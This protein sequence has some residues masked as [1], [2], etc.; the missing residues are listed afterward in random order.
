MEMLPMGESASWTC[1][2]RVTIES[3][4]LGLT[5]L[6]ALGHVYLH[7]RIYN[8]R[9]ATEHVTESGLAFA[10]VKALC[11]GIFTRGVLLDVCAARGVEWL[12]PGEKIYSAD[13]NAA[14][15]LAGLTVGAGDAI[16]V[17]SGIERRERAQSAAG[18]CGTARPCGGGDLVV[19]R[20]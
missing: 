20:T 2:D 14:E 6:D 12:Q 10:D 1:H 18:P 3:H 11:E 15:Q 16:F 13:L 7:G 8:G 17:H 19:V 5:H 4:T 9:R